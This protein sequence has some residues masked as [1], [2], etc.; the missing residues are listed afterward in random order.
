MPF[1]ERKHG[2]VSHRSAIVVSA[3]SSYYYSNL[4]QVMQTELTYGHF[5]RYTK[6]LF[7]IRNY[8]VA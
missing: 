2:F 5:F 1:G 4:E 7:T 3:V 6:F 8:W